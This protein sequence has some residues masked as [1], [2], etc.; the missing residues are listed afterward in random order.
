V[1]QSL[2]RRS[3]N[4]LPSSVVSVTN[5]SPVPA[6]IGTSMEDSPVLA[7]RAAG[8]QLHWVAHWAA[9]RAA[10]GRRGRARAERVPA[11]ASPRRRR[12]GGAAVAS[13][14]GLLD[15]RRH[16][17]GRD[18]L[19][20][21]LSPL[22][23]DEAGHRGRP[24]PSEH[25]PGNPF[26]VPRVHRGRDRIKHRA[27]EP[28]EWPGFRATTAALRRRSPADDRVELARRDPLWV[29]LSPLGSEEAGPSSRRS[30]DGDA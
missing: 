24:T 11:A 5:T 23:N 19:W 26:A 2:A 17:P 28:T 15:P 4:L 9:R 10:R 25:V 22:V 1:L 7:R 29:A 27:L 8:H 16:R 13:A 3:G 6:V 18:P 12:A 20:V 30:L 21:A 14:A